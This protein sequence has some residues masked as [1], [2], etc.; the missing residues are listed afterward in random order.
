MGFSWVIRGTLISAVVIL[1]IGKT[2]LLHSIFGCCISKGFCFQIYTFS[3]DDL[4]FNCNFQ[5]V[6]FFNS[7]GALSLLLDDVI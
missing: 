3:Y 4:N 2:V 5:S 1:G 6:C 7:L